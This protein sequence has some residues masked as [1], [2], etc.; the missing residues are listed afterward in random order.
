[1]IGSVGG[2]SGTAVYT[3]VNK[4]NQLGEF[5]IKIGKSTWSQGKTIFKT[6]IV[7]RGLSILKVGKGAGNIFK[8]GDNV[9]GKIIQK[10][11]PGSNGK[12]AI[13]GRKMAGH[14]EDA[15]ATLRAEGKQVEIFSKLDQKNNLF[16]INGTNKSWQD[17]VDDFGNKSGQY[18]TNDK[19]WIL[20][21]ELPKTMM[22][23]ANKIWADK[24]KAQ[25]Y[26]VIDIGYPSGASLPQSVFYNM[27]ISTLFP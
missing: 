18:L 7:S 14:V 3:A 2:A 11:L 8:V 23:K 22:Y 24:L 4:L 6:L 16:N 1:M 5:T 17:I 21:S 12:V 13:V 27:E 26:T 9:A 19:G 25:G 10:V 20:D 15:A